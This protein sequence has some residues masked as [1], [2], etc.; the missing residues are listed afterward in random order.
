MEASVAKILVVDDEPGAGLGLAI[1][2][3]LVE[4]H[5]GSIDVESAPGGGS[6]F[7]FRIPVAN[8]EAR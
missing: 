4:A 7:R 2:R 8:I 6:T 1:T 3:G 5:G